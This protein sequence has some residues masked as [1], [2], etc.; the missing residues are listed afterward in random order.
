MKKILFGNSN[1]DSN[2]YRQWI[3]GDFLPTDSPLKTGKVE[4]KW[5]KHKKNEQKL[6]GPQKVDRKTLVILVYGKFKIK[7]PASQEE[8]IL[9]NEG[10]YLYFD[11][12]ILHSWV[13]VEDTLILTIRWSDD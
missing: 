6:D 5:G 13:S 2:N 3:V 12:D 4:I 1:K 11:K 10:D 9:E 7:L 8:F